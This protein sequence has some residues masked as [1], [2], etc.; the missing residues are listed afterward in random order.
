MILSVGMMVCDTVL[1]PVPD[2]IL[3]RDCAMIDKPVQS[4]GGDAL[5]TA[6]GLAKLSC[7]VAIAGKIGNDSNGKFL[8]DVCRQHGVDAGGVVI[9]EEYSTACSYALI[10]KN[11]ERHFLSEINIF[12]DLGYED[13]NTELIKQADVVYVGSLLAM[14]KMN[15]DGIHR[16]FK[17]AHEN[18]CLTVMDAA[19]NDKETPDINKILPEILPYADVFFPSISEASAMAGT[20]DIDEIVKWFKKYGCRYFGIKLGSKGCF[21]TDFKESR[22]IEPPKGLPVVDT[23]GAGDSFMAGL[24]CAMTNGKPFFEAAAFGTV[25]GSFNV[26][27]Q[28]ATAGIPTYQEAC[29][30]YE[31]WKH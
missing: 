28:G 13:I 17:L 21:V 14:K 16:I 18:D 29:A 5:N 4:C 7:K 31:K 30:F 25:I 1:S 19:I 6:I 10:D 24:V 15:N 8:L 27:K 26:G 22:Y 20:E 2:D 11:G 23:S 12:N 3:T 9:S